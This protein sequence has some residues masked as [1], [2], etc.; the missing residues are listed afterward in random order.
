MSH[1][2]PKKRKAQKTLYQEVVPY[3]IESVLEQF[4]NQPLTEAT[5]EAAVRTAVEQ[6][7][8]YT[9]MVIE[10]KFKLDNIDQQ[11]NPT[12]RQHS[13]QNVSHL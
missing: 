13:C 6:T 4:K 7:F 11:I 2:T 9:L 3:K 8:K 5:F 1:L 12:Q 10:F